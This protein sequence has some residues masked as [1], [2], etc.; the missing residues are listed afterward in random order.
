MVD[1][2]LPVEILSAGCWLAVAK[3]VRHKLNSLSIK[4]SHKLTTVAPA[5]TATTRVAGGPWCIAKSW[6]CPVGWLLAG[7]SK[8]MR[9]KSCSFLASYSVFGLKVRDIYP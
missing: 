2:T 6:W 1:P 3:N 7:C 9:D 5:K 4:D 8:K